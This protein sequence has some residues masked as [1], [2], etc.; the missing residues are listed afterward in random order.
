VV[1]TGSLLATVMSQA[2]PDLVLQMF[3][4]K[5]EN[6][7]EAD[8]SR[9]KVCDVFALRLPLG[10]SQTPTLEKSHLKS[11]SDFGKKIYKTK[12][13]LL[14]SNFSLGPKEEIWEVFDDFVFL[15]FLRAGI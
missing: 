14:P 13:A 10:K 11:F 2:R 1:E 9:G 7:F 6:N 8:F 12:P 15:K 5:L 3:F 4:P